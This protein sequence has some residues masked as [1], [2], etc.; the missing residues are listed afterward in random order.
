MDRRRRELRKIGHESYR[1]G[2][3]VCTSGQPSLTTDLQDSGHRHRIAAPR[4]SLSRFSL[5]LLSLFAA[6]VA[7]V[8]VLTVGDERLSAPRPAQSVEK[9]TT[10][11]LRL[12]GFTFE[13]IMISGH[14]RTSEDTIYNALGIQA[15]Q[16]FLSFDLDAARRRLQSLPSIKSVVLYR[17]Y[18]GQLDIAIVEE[19][20]VALWRKAPDE[21]PFAVA[22]EGQVLGLSRPSDKEVSLLDIQGTG[23]PAALS[24]LLDFLADQA[25]LAK[26]VR[27]A[28]RVGERRWNVTL[29]NGA[30]IQ[31]PAEGLRAVGR[32]A[33]VQQILRQWTRY[34][35]QVIDLRS[36][37]RI[38]V[39][40]RTYVP[41]SE[42]K[43]EVAATQAN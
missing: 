39:R 38:S 16:S 28:E 1:V 37:G 27:S 23:A 13:Q 19:A 11:L 7:G 15:Q 3:V 21:R 32:R 43:K 36:S 26:S 5:T 22:S 30:V 14:V 17:V 12:A 25:D 29:L 4:Q 6:M 10:T 33:K 31:L 2:S 8:F 9:A 34:A 24:E 40:K 18:P 35:N 41:R 42:P 20:P